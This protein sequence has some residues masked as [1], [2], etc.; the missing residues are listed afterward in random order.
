MGLLDRLRGRRDGG[1]GHGNGGGTAASAAGS[2]T[3][4]GP[5]ADTGS[6]TDAAAGAP[7][8]S[9]PGPAPVAVAAWTG[10]PPIQRTTG[11]DR[12]GVAD[13]AFGG[14]LPTWQD[15]SFSR[16]PSP[17]VLDPGAG[18]SLLSG[19]FDAS[20]RRTSSSSVSSST[21]LAR[22]AGAP[23]VQ[24]MPVAPL[25]AIPADAPATAT[26]PTAPTGSAPRARGGTSSTPGR[27]AASGPARTAAP[28]STAPAAAPV[29]RARAGG[30]AAP[31]GGACGAAP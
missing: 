24:R 23:P 7:A 20:A 6:P 13:A 15:P 17:A 29:Q 10:L 27:A 28:S 5:P 16:A 30:A 14:R 21:P 19:A 8:A 18:D 31:P 26:A 1:E 22:P 9:A 4:T 3:Q 11:A 12:T 2:P 25:R